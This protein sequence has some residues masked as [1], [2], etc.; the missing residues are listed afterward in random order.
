MKINA[1]SF[2]L[3]AL[4][5][6]PMVAKAV[7]TTGFETFTSPGQVADQGGWTI[8][9]PQAD[10]SFLVDNPPA[11]KYGAL[12]GFLSSPS[13][14]MANVNLRHDTGGFT[15]A[16]G[17]TFTARYALINRSTLAAPNDFPASDP[18][19]WFGFTLGN[20]VDV[21]SLSFRPTATENVRQVF[22]NNVAVTTQNG[23]TTSDYA[24]PA[25][26]TVTV[27]FQNVG[28]ALQYT[29]SLGAGTIPL[30]GSI[31]A[32][33][34]TQFTTIDIDYDVKNANAGQNVIF[35]DG[36]SLVPEPSAAMMGLLSLGLLAGR[37]R[38]A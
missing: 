8:N 1:S 4:F 34:A 7:Y 21:F 15:L 10:L 18:N 22:V 30:S 28:G 20:G 31:F 35:V 32:A 3:L 38:R 2:I 5:A 29:G 37:R 9:D 11:N 26:D 27:S 24:N 23:I 19:D 12:G 17:T 6:T 14:L 36:L 13:T 16:S 25:F 33:G